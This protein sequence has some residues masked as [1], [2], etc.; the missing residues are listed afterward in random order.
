MSH[1]RTDKT[2]W[3][4]DPG[5]TCSDKGKKISRSFPGPA[6]ATSHNAPK[7]SKAV[8]VAKEETR[9]VLRFGWSLE[10]P[11]VSSQLI[12]LFMRSCQEQQSAQGLGVTTS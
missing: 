9:S 4:L 6:T 11:R 3:L 1:S 5:E 8:T 10:S 7:V 12:S 2:H